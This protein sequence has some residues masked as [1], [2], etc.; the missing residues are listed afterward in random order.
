MASLETYW[1]WVMGH[2][3]RAFERDPHDPG[4]ATRFGIDIAS[5]Q[6]FE[7]KGAIPGLVF[8]NKATITPDDIEGLDEYRAKIFYAACWWRPMRLDGF[9]SERLAAKLFDTAINLGLVGAT[10]VFQQAA[11]SLGASLSVDGG[12]GPKTIAAIKICDEQEF[13]RRVCCIQATRY[14]AIVAAR[15]DS[16]HYLGGWL[17]RASDLP[18]D[19]GVAS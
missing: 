5:A 19:R 15:P 9:K 17:K 4:G 3:G 6:D 2:E 8:G 1:D 14:R 18:P 7:E 13:L 10:I 12:L 11:N 16:A